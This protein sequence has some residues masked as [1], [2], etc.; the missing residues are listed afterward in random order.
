MC[1]PATRPAP[2]AP[3]AMPLATNGGPRMEGAV[4]NGAQDKGDDMTDSELE[5]IEDT[6]L[7]NVQLH[8]PAELWTSKDSKVTVHLRCDP[9]Y[10]RDDRAVALESQPRLSST[11]GPVLTGRRRRQAGFGASRHAPERELSVFPAKRRPLFP[12]PPPKL[13]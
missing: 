11:P 9:R 7:N 2:P 8:T 5:A 13:P 3:S 12:A 6:M 1:K 4:E 10:S